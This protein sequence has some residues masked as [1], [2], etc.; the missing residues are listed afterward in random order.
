[1]YS[2]VIREGGREMRCSICE[3]RCSLAEGGVGKCKMYIQKNGQIEERLPNSYLAATPISIETMPILHFAQG[4]KFL[5]I[6]SVG[7]NF[8]C[9]GCISTILVEEAVTVEDA[10]IHLEPEEVAAKALAEACKGIVFCLNDPTVSYFTF[11]RV[12]MAAKAQGIFVG[13]S[14]NLYLTEEALDGLLPFID[15]VNVGLKGFSAQNYL[16]SGIKSPQAIFRNVMKLFERGIHFE[17]SIAHIKGMENE[18]LEC[19]QFLSGLSKDIPFQVMRFI[20]FAG[21]T[22]DMEPDI[23]ESEALCDQL[24]EIMNYV[25]LFNSP[26]SSRLTTKCPVCKKPLIER[27]FFGPMGAHIT[28]HVE[29]E[30]CSC[31]APL[32]GFHVDSNEFV[33]EGFMGGYRL[34]RAMEMLR[35]I[36]E[37]IGVRDEREFVRIWLSILSDNFL[38]EFHQK[39]GNIDGYLEIIGYLGEKSGHRDESLRLVAYMRGVCARIENGIHNKK[40][41]RVLYTMG[42]PY[43]ALNRGRM[44]NELVERA[45]GISLNRTLQREGKPGVTLSAAHMEELAPEI[46]VTSGFIA[47]TKES[48]LRYLSAQ[49]ARP[50]PE[51]YVMPPCWDFGSPRFIFGVMYLANALHP[52]EFCF[53][54]ARERAFF[55]ETFYGLDRTFTEQNRSFY[56]VSI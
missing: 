55:Y 34:T 47:A 52:D 51:V 35:A 56:A 12:S 2:I 29:G 43:F 25:Y 3:F 53:D 50:V 44:E 23:A 4:A 15:F 42:Y 20:S 8:R 18:V 37:S 9:S 27:E 39:T 41:P 28:T 46:I 11:K 7:C 32:A 10:L 5:Q 22:L 14:S 38:K 13:F 1:M 21:A 6:S 48:S 36:L 49:S 54:I 31:G 40:K 16:A 17:I 33:E 45:G 26:G 24:N 30:Q 19:A